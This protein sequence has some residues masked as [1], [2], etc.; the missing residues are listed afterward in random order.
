[1]STEVE[2]NNCFLYDFSTKNENFQLSE[3]FNLQ[4]KDFLTS[5][6]RCYQNILM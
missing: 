3:M 2:V 6:I 4:P 1:M 5:F